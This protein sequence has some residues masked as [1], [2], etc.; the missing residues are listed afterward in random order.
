M[1]VWRVFGGVMTCGLVL[2]GLYALSSDYSTMHISKYRAME[3]LHFFL[4]YTTI[5]GYF[6]LCAYSAYCIYV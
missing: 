6:C 4:F 1:R 2:V 3:T 5:E